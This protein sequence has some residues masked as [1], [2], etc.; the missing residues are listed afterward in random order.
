[1]RA[2]DKVKSLEQMAALAEAA[3]NAGRRVVLAHGVFDLVH[4]GHIRHLEQAAAEGDI[5]LVTLTADR[6]VNKGPGRPIFGEQLRAEML[7]A[8]GFVTCVAINPTATAVEVLRQVKPDVYIKGS[9]YENPDED[10]TGKIND[11]RTAVESHGGRIVFTRDI[12]F[13]SSSLINRYLDVYDQPLRDFLHEMREQGGLGAIGELVNAVAGFRL[14]FVGETIIDEYQYVTVVG[15]S[16][17]ENM[18]AT[19][20][21]GSEAF[22]GGV[23]A[24][25]NHAADFCREV[26]VV[27]VFGGQ[28]ADRAEEM[29]RAILKPNVRLTALRRPDTPTIRKSRFVDPIYVRKL[30]EV[31]FMN[32]SPLPKSLTDELDKV[33]AEKAPHA[34]ATVVTDFGHGMIG[35]STI[36]TLVKHA[37]FLAVNAQSNSA[38][39]GFNLITRYPRADYV[40]IDA[41]EAR[42]A[43]GERYADIADIASEVLP[44]RIDCPRIV[45]THGK[46][47][48]YAHQQGASLRCIPAF[49]KTVTDTMGAGDAF[50]AV[51]APLAAAGGRMEHVGFVGNAAGAI[52][53]GIIGHRQSVEK[54]PLMKFVT[55]L[56]K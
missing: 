55:A 37:R 22:A 24:A 36:D 28:D 10:I 11:E 18:I 35:R 20:F 52:K 4:L 26:E 38:N 43:V 32:D 33:I 47:G 49:T 39:M 17:K 50:F 2:R 48:C 1:M 3:R 27:T 54:V 9:D 45:I 34:D 30:F 8:V 29:V 42:L 23:I 12:T 15:K 21:Q 46:D 7:A 31:Q 25:A 41:P 19:R 16:P 51:T 53:V 6:H 40:C 5:L 44:G 13:S 56:L 14:L